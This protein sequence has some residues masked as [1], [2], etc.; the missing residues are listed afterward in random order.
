MPRAI[1]TG[2][3]GFIGGNLSRHL[4]TNGW[5]VVAFH[6]PSSSSDA[7]ESLRV[8]GVETASFSTVSE[9]QRLAAEARPDA[10]FH[11]AA[12]QAKDYSA[13]DIDSFLDA[14]VAVGTHLLEGLINSTCVFVNAVSYF[15]FRDG[16]PA[17]HSL[18]SATKQAFVD[19][20]TFYR[21]Q[22]GMDIRHAVLYD[23]FGPGDSRMKLIPQLLGA[24][25]A[26]TPIALGPSGQPINALYIDDV[27][28]GLTAASAPGNPDFMTV[29][30]TH[31]V[32]VGEVVAK[33]ELLAGVSL[34]TS[35]DASRNP[36]D[37]VERSGS[38]P[39]PANWHPRWALQEA[40]SRTYQS[41]RR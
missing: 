32:T 29:K 33:V 35:F 7:L 16:K 24:A 17:S 1:V 37:M 39:L 6:R 11:L 3:T 40:L 38:W 31:D 34:E 13:A 23:S 14:N 5:D 9:L 30:A 22:R 26:R 10:V 19:I 20:S 18:Y 41:I 8:Y 28:S 27:V 15:Q 12:Y 21:E 4:H 2:A 36:N 25:R